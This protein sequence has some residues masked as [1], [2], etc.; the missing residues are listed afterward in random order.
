MS[1]SAASI[2]IL[3]VIAVAPST[4]PA[5]D[6]MPDGSSTPFMSDTLVF[7]RARQ[8]EKGK[9]CWRTSAQVGDLWSSDSSSKEVTSFS[10]AGPCKVFYHSVWTKS[11]GVYDDDFMFELRDV[12]AIDVQPG[13]E[14]RGSGIAYYRATTFPQIFRLELAGPAVRRTPFEFTFTDAS[15]RGRIAPPLLRALELCGGSAAIRTGNLS[16][17][18][19]TLFNTPPAAKPVTLSGPAVTGTMLQ[20]QKILQGLGRLDHSLRTVVGS[21][22]GGRKDRF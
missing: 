14:E 1:R 3:L 17:A 22:G 6:S 4:A 15:M 9:I 21:C 11:G 2:L 10:D 19:L 16:S 13:N 8:V 5:Q 7:I 12:K 18:E 20:I